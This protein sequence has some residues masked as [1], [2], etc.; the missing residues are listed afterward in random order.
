MVFKSRQV[1][2]LKYHSRYLVP[3]HYGIKCQFI[4]AIR[5]TINDGQIFPC[6][7]IM[8]TFRVPINLFVTLAV[9]NKEI[10]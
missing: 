3:T 2:Q 7:I 4:A 10:S 8:S 1:D 6:W 5:S 9:T